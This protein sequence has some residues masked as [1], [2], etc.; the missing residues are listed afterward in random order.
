MNRRNILRVIGLVM[1]GSLPSIS[2]CANVSSKVETTSASPTSDISSH[3]TYH[4]PVFEPILADPT[5]IRGPDDWFYVY[6]TT[7]DWHDGDGRRIVPLI[8]SPDLVHW[9]Y[10]GEVFDAVPHWLDGATS[11]WAPHIVSHNGRYKL[12]YSLV[13]TE[14]FPEGRGIGVATAEH[15]A[16]PF[17]DHGEVLRS[18]TIGV[19]DSID[20]AVIVEDGTPY[21]VWGSQV[22]GIYV[23]QLS[24]DGTEPVGEKTRIASD[25]FE[26]AYIIKRHGYYYLFVSSGSCCDGFESEYQVEVARATS[27]TGPYRNHYGRSLLES[28]GRLVV[29]H[30][31]AFAAPGHNAVIT[32][33]AGTDWLVY[34]AYDRSHDAFLEDIPRR[35]LMIDPLVWSNGWPQITGTFPSTRERTPDIDSL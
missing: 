23:V 5:I 12:Y 21:L 11:V 30:S 26:G 24:A 28:H 6:G 25:L 34:H 9:E 17:V 18:G 27:I 20:P 16:G 35:S 19:D 32:D 13:N 31:D 3:R 8:R 29:D 10:V 4:N 2:G 7:T 15:P 14:E 33:D 1:T 22:D